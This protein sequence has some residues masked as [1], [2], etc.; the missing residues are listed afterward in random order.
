[1]P[2]IPAYKELPLFKAEPR[3][4]NS[5]ELFAV[6]LGIG[7]S[8]E[9]FDMLLELMSTAFSVGRVIGMQEMREIFLDKLNLDRVKS[10]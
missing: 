1:M 10:I 4:L 2:T 3:L 8:P 7:Q 5:F 6:T 9:Y